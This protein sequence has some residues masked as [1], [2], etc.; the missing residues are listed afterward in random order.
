MR[1]GV[2]EVFALEPDLRAAQ[3]LGQAL[4]VIH[5]A[6]AADVVLELG[7]ELGLELRIVAH[8]QVLALELV[9]GVDQ[10]LGDEHAAVGTEMAVGVGQVVDLPGFIHLH[11][12]L[13][14]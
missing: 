11:R 1:A 8:A 2:V 7:R 5:R 3:L 14:E 13:L 4:G 10:R 12:A 9:Q 6:G